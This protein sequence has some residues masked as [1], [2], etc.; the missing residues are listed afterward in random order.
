M[1][2]ENAVSLGEAQNRAAPELRAV[3]TFLRSKNGPKVRRGILNGSR[4]DYFKGKA[5]VKA[6]LTPAFKK[7]KNAPK[8]ETEEDAVALLLKL[9]PHAFFLRVDRPA[10]TPPTPS[11]QPKILAIAP[12]QSFDPAAYYVWFIA[13][14]PLSTYIG[15]A[16]MVAV[17]LA[18]VM[19]PLWPPIMRQG[20][21]YLSMGVLGLIALFIGIAVVRLIFWAITSVILRKGIWW[22]PN[23]FEDVGFVDSFIPFWAWDEPAQPAGK[24]KSSKSSKE[25]RSSKNK[26]SSASALG[27][28]AQTLAAEASAAVTG[29]STP[30]SGE[31]TDGVSANASK[32]LGDAPSTGATPS[33]ADRAQG[34]AMEVG[35]DA[36]MRKRQM[37]YVEDVEE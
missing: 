27:T 28:T 5:A 4:S 29:A 11:G 24:S 25:K 15:S 34:S 18:G 33:A 12:Q 37:A 13:S 26:T 3:A 17:M 23:L 7:V 6:L 1:N 30:I 20:V 22:F 9:L 35:G 14:S 21:S 36:N 8:V 16:A 32:G 10:Q 2:P 19:F 31:D